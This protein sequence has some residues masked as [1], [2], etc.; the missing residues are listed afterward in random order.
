[1]GRKGYAL[2]KSAC[3]YC[4]NAMLKSELKTDHAHVAHLQWTYTKLKII[5][6]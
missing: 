4:L 6:G 5:T 2:E 1:M 3:T